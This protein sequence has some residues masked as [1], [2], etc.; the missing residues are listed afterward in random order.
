M[1]RR[2][3]TEE[4]AG[5]GFTLVELL[6]VIGIIALLIAILMP[7]LSRARKQ[8]LQVSCGSNERQQV[9]AAIAYTNDWK[10]Q[11]PPSTGFGTA[12]FAAEMNAAMCIRLPIIGFDTQ[13]VLSIPAFYSPANM[14]LGGWGYVLRDYLKND[15]DVVICPDGWFDTAGVF[16]PLDA[17]WDLFVTPR[18]M[19]L[20]AAMMGHDTGM[21]YVWLPH[22]QIVTNTVGSTSAGCAALACAANTCTDK[23]RNVV[24]TASDKP[25]LLVVTDYTLWQCF[26]SGTPL[27]ASN[28]QALSNKG[29]I[30]WGQALPFTPSNLAATDPESLPLGRN[31]ARV[32]CR[33]E[34]LPGPNMDYFRWTGGYSPQ[35]HWFAW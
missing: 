25:E 19:I 30:I 26:T 21:G 35:R 17:G 7:A 18:M 20:N 1:F 34:W 11:L 32:D 10:E 2:S 27:L 28:H 22:R 5:G 23:P 14:G 13:T 16:K 6:V 9:Y 12:W 29:G 24:K 8:A 4:R 15:K 33:T 31:A 3:K